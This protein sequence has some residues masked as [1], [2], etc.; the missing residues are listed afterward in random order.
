MTQLLRFSLIG[1]FTC[2]LLQAFELRSWTDL[3]GRHIEAAMS[4]A[5]ETAVTLKL[6]DGQTLPFPLAKLSEADRQYVKKSLS[7]PNLGSTDPSENTPN[8]DSPWPQVVKFSDKPEIVTIKEEPKTKTFI[9]ESANYRYICDV[10]LSQSVVQ[11]FAAMFESTHLY[12]RELPLGLCAGEKTDGKLPITLFEN[13]EDYHKAGGPSETAGVF[14]S[15]KKGVLV[16]LTS[17]GVRPVGSGYMFDHAK[18]SNTLPHELTH[19]LTPGSYFSKGFTGWFTE[20]IAEY[21]GNTPYR[22][23][24]YIVRGSQRSLMEYVTAYGARSMG[25]RALGKK[26]SL[27]PLKTFMFQDY[28]TFTSTPQTNYGCGLLLT[29]YFLQMDGAGDAARLKN[30]L[31]A[32]TNHKSPAEATACLLDGRTYEQLEKEITKAWRQ[33]GVELTFDK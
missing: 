21:V 9:Y 22:S 15:G 31:K 7:S 26:I 23:G 16:P 13:F 14:I 8:F 6:L 4:N 5:D 33:S 29:I 24:T 10:R 27:P 20:G 2:S 28:K 18:S 32:L 19:Q 12:C 25:G 17:L 11:G 30:S 1:L 3:Q